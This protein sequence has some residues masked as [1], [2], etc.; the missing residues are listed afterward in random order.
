MN[1]LKRLSIAFIFLGMGGTLIAQTDPTGNSSSTARV[2]PF[3]VIQSLLDANSSGEISLVTWT[4]AGLENNLF[5]KFDVNGDEKLDQTEIYSARTQLQ[6]K[7]KMWGQDG[8]GA[9]STHRM[10]WP[11]WTGFGNASGTHDWQGPNGSGTDGRFPPPPNGKGPRGV[12]GNAS[13]THDW[14][15]PNASGTDGRFPPPP[16]GKGPRGGFGNASGTHDWRGPNASGT[17]GRFPPPPN[18]KGPR[19]GFGNASDSQDWQQDQTG[20]D[21]PKKPSLWT[22]FKEKVSSFFSFLH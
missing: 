10:K 2:P 5:K 20:R 4:N 16:N 8:A 17:D 19:G 9:S 21:F 13:G 1:T 15:G 7:Q 6:K 3:Q 22:R 11:S 12:F 14:R 18:G